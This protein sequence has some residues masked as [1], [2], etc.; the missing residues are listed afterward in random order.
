MIRRALA[1]ASMLM[2]TAGVEAAVAASTP[3]VLTRAAS[4]L[5]N[6]SAVLNASV[7]P[8][9]SRTSYQ[10]QYGLTPAYGLTTSP[11][12]IGSGTAVLAVASSAAGLTPG[13]VYHFR[14]LATNGLGS[15]FGQDRTFKTAGFPPPTP[16]TGAA[17]RVDQTSATV[18]GTIN[19]NG[20]ATDWLFQYG[21]SQFLGLQQTLGGTVLPP[22]LSSSVSATIPGLAP[23]TTFYYRL[24]AYH[25]PGTVLN[26]GV[27][28]SFTTVPSVRP[29]PRVRARTSPLRVARRPYRFNTSG[30]I[31]LPRSIPPVVGCVGTVAIRFRGA[32]GRVL[33][34]RFSPVKPNCTFDQQLLF[35]RLINGAGAILRIEINFRGNRYL[36]PAS[37]PAQRVRLG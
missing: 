8:N 26:Y 24:V 37:V 3:S 15:S 17:S 31:L 35:Q 32:G 22:T 1:I 7:N 16:V 29:R 30:S 18:T 11:H 25:G 21:V 20:Q 13:S 36:A 23:G 9:G 10:F 6:G 4:S 5:T 34:S 33:A 19:L 12:A 28:Q 27:E 14:V 2:L